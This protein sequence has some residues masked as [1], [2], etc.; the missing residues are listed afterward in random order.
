ME[1]ILLSYASKHGSTEQ[2]AQYLAENLRKHSFEV[3][4]VPAKAV[5]SLDG[6]AAVILG[7]AVYVGN[8]TDEAMA[9]LKRFDSALA[10]LPVYF[11]STGPTGEGD[12]AEL[13]QG[14]QYPEA[15]Q[16]YVDHIRPESIALFHGKLE[17]NSL[18]LIQRLMVKAIKA[19]VGDYRKWDAIQAWAETIAQTLLPEGSS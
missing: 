15:I 6:Y 16:S 19:P 7:S 13:L 8:W 2:I 11:F 5:E 18:P 17:L 1:R 14:W 10:K 12:P 9:F 4:V 3:H